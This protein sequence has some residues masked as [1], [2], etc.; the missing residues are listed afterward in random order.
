[1]SKND[2][3]KVPCSNYFETSIDFDIYLP[4]FQRGMRRRSD[5]SFRSYMGRDVIMISQLERESDGPTEMS[6]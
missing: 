4:P 1:M 5:V 3:Q 6:L 2:Q